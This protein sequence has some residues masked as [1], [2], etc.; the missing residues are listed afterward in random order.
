MMNRAICV[1]MAHATCLLVL[2]AVVHAQDF[3]RSAP[4]RILGY[5]PPG[6]PS[7]ILPRAM[8]APLSKAF[9][10]PVVVENRVGADG[11]IA[12]EQ[13]AK[14]APDGHTLCIMSSSMLSVYP[15]IQKVPYDPVR[16]FAP[17]TFLAYFDSFLLAH[18][19]VPANSVT[20]LIALAKA[21]PNAINWGHF[22]LATV[23]S[24]YQEYI[25]KNRSAPFY[26]V[27]YK[28]NPQMLQAIMTGEASV[29]VFGVA[30]AV[31]PIK[32]GKMKALAVTSDKRLA[33]FPSVPTFDEEGIKL[34][35]RGWYGYNMTASAPRAIVNRWNTEIRR[36]MGESS[37]R[38]ILQKY[39]MD[40]RPGTPEQFDA[41]VRNQLKEMG[42]LIAYIDFKPQ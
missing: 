5:A 25:K 6:A 1:R 24:F 29:G 26:P 20:E 39:G 23:G 30:N 9:G 31:A 22:G 33:E 27:P 32:A 18:P 37:Y 36:A 41:L 19:S 11:M 17:V 35:L 15:I 14:S 8:M 40:A 13:C 38:D 10:Q 4:I 21:K 2:T 3:P 16:D 34:P 42:E 12:A 7:D 28:T